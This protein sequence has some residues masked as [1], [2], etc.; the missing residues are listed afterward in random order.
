MT[1][2]GSKIR[3]EDREVT[4]AI[5]RVLMTLPLGGDGRPLFKMIG[6]RVKTDVQLRFREQKSP[7]GVPWIPSRRVI[8]HGGQTLRLTGQLRNSITYQ[9]DHASV[10]IGTNKV[11]ARRQHSGDGA[12]TQSIFNALKAGRTVAR[13]GLPARPF[14]GL[15]KQGSEGLIDA[16]NGFLGKTWAR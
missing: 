6:R 13:T 7:E 14:M 2:D 12:R 16:V 1:I 8:E 4:A 11:Y 15:S 9:A 10:E 5:R 3:I